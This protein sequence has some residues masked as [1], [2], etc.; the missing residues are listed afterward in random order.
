M[1]Y[2]NIH[3]S[4]TRT[5][6]DAN[7]YIWKII[8]TYFEDNPRSLVNH[9]IQSFND[10]YNQ[11]IYQVFRDTN[12]V[13]L[14][15]KFVNGEF[16]H[17]CKLYFGGKNGD[18]VYFG[19][20]AIYD[21]N[22]EHFMFPNEARLR[23][24]TYGMTI[25]YDIEVE[26][27][28]LLEEN[29]QPSIFTDEYLQQLE[30]GEIELGEED[31]EDNAEAFTGLFVQG[32]SGKRQTIKTNPKNAKQ[33]REKAQSTVHDRRTQALN[34]AIQ[35]A[36]QVSNT[37]QDSKTRVQIRN[38]VLEKIYLGRFPIM[39][40][41][42]MCILSGMTR[43][44]RLA[45]GE[46]KNDLGGYFI[47]DGKEKAVIPQEKLGD[48]MLNIRNFE[49]SNDNPD[50]TVGELEF[51]CTAEIKSVS[52]NIAK[53]RRT[54]SLK[55]VAPTAKY[56]NRNIVVNI[57]NVRKPVPLFIV[58]RALGIVSDKDI[59]Q[60]CLL[61]LDKYSDLVDLFIPCVHDAEGILTQQSA[62]YFISLLTK[63]KS[64]AY[65]HEI[66]TDYLLPHVGEGNYLEKAYYLGYMV[67]RM[68]SVHVG[69]E[70]PI[71]RD[72]FKYKRVE[73]VGSLIS[74]LFREYLTIQNKAY[75]LAFESRLYFNEQRYEDHLDLLIY[76]YYKEICKERIVETG[77]R[78]AFKGNWGSVAHTKRIGI[79]QDLNRLSF[80]S[81]IAHLRKVCLPM[82]SSLK[83]VEPR[84]LHPSQWGFIDPLDTP[85]GGNIGFHKNLAIST[86]ISR[87]C[88]R[89]VIL[90][91]LKAN[92]KVIVLEDLRP[93]LMANMSK[94]IVN[95]YWFACIED[96]LEAV[97]KMKLYRRNA[98]I[99]IHTSIAF[100][101]RLNTLFI[102]TDAGRLCRPIFYFDNGVLSY[103][104]KVLEGK[105]TW[106]E[107]IS[108]FNKKEVSGFDPNV[109]RIYSLKELYG[110]SGDQ[111]PALHD[112]FIKHKAMIDFIDCN[113][114]E[115]ALIALGVSDTDSAAAVGKTHCEIHESLIFG[116]MCNQI[117]FPENNQSP[118]D[119]FSCGQSKQACSMFH[120]NFQVRMDKTGIVLNYGQAPLVKTRYGTLINKEENPYGE[121][122][123]VAIMC[124]SGYNVEDAVLINEGAIKRGLFRTT[125]F[126]TYE[127]KEEHNK[128]D[129]DRWT[130]TILTNPN[131]Y[132][133]K[134]KLKAG[135]S[136]D[137]LD[138]FGIIREGVYVN[139]ET[140]LIGMSVNQ[141]N[142]ERRDCSI[143]PKKGQLGIVDKVFV[144][145]D[146]EGKRLIK[147]RVLDQRIPAMGDKFA[148]RVGQKGT[149]GIVIPER[150]MPFTKDGLIPDII[151]NPHA[152]PSR[153]T[154]GQIIESITGKVCTMYGGF[155]DC[156]AFN[157]KGSKAELFGKLLTKE[158]FHASGNEVLYNGMTGEQVEAD[159]FIGPT[160]YM[161]LKHMVKDKIN[162]RRQG[163]NAMLTRQPVG[164]RA[165]DGGL[166]VGEMER[167]TIAS[168]GAIEFLRESM[169]ERAD[170]YKLA[171]CNKTGTIAIHNQGQNRFLSPAVDGPIQVQCD[172][173]LCKTMVT[174]DEIKVDMVS[175]YG[176]DFSIVHVPYS[177]KLL[178][179]ELQ[180][181]NVQ[182]RIITEDNIKQLNNLMGNELQ[183]FQ[184]TNSTVEFVYGFKRGFDEKTLKPYWE[185]K[186]G[187]KVLKEPQVLIDK[188]K[189]SNMEMLRDYRVGD[190]IYYLDESVSMNPSEKWKIIAID[191]EE[192]TM[193]MKNIYSLG[194]EMEK[195][196]KYNIAV[197][198]LFSKSMEVTETNTTNATKKTHANVAYIQQVGET[199]YGWKLLESKNYPGRF[200]WGDTTGTDRPSKWTEPEE[201][202]E[203]RNI[204]KLPISE[205]CFQINEQFYDLSKY[206]D[207]EN[208]AVSAEEVSKLY[209][210]K[211]RFYDQD[212][213]AYKIVLENGDQVVFDQELMRLHKGYL[214][215]TPNEPPPPSTT[216][217]QIQTGGRA[218]K[219]HSH[220]LSAIDEL[221]PPGLATSEL[222]SVTEG[223]PLNELALDTM[224][225]WGKDPN[226]LHRVWYIRNL[227][228]D[229]TY[230]I[231]T[232]DVSGLQTEDC[233]QNVSREELTEI[234]KEDID[235]MMTP[236]CPDPM[237][238]NASNLPQ[239]MVFAPM[240]K[241]INNGA[242]NSTCATDPIQPS[243]KIPFIGMGG[244]GS[245]TTE[246]TTTSS[247]PISAKPTETELDSGDGNGE[248]GLFS[249][250]ASMAN[251]FI[252]KKLL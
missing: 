176:R 73:V 62:L 86:Q 202:T 146:E 200:Y 233:Y 94:V 93:S 168:H 35:Q 84:K 133:G 203:R 157:Q 106:N 192:G 172:A 199:I 228:E 179:Q 143:V 80:N 23:N 92:L 238:M 75:H 87:G 175:K 50:E 48:N 111:N 27:I 40:Q 109:P 160:Y 37:S 229:G 38:L 170:K 95:G 30:R 72:N 251:N 118:R 58:F 163:N 211:E 241:V 171:I 25:H 8:E 113:E 153:M 147:V 209:R 248:G 68:L 115:T 56:S 57:P 44:T 247:E 166:R 10:F 156:T 52:E 152:I 206:E 219:K 34:Q 194:D 177:L 13:T 59:I 232:D 112:K 107:L 2:Y 117:A 63:W 11:G 18:R 242:D 130:D 140:I 16:K 101:A 98:L 231:A 134:I 159:I 216:T 79:V 162:Y 129:D 81:M 141:E 212:Y 155:A 165:N 178:M 190:I 1:F 15:S 43:E 99:P 225:Y 185:D 7:E 150:D 54:L 151:V 71:D 220:S 142:G 201:I 12:P 149:I 65:V 77:F 227:G 88:S 144:T 223:C 174:D 128:E 66:L 90:P 91:W 29:E 83:I 24:M 47:I 226:K 9:H 19:K 55:L 186:E 236:A 249:K 164:G 230:Y 240:I 105:F 20:P 76:N 250:M 239:G 191:D 120:T 154:V 39:V 119:L 173:K 60:T 5:H 33:L 122:A 243:V 189:L 169:M 245:K 237:N 213:S 138:E 102:Y 145:D 205:R 235:A 127:A 46:C 214:P 108:G 167:D 198:R 217:Q 182:M 123:I 187:K 197:M 126:T 82:D 103:D 207:I 70:K 180:A 32:G 89:E 136:Y 181:I 45:A 221:Y 28:D 135:Y 85:D 100:D 224:V 244:G 53:P 6:D 26:F 110:I 196:C 67:S 139:D 125:Y 131:L 234:P 49:T 17:Q 188:R 208:Q 210:V 78:K 252:V 74:D 69:I 96:P 158:K 4:D 36:A 161:R 116:V 41:S 137:K 218:T 22:R 148:S 61:D 14:V 97:A 104:A 21:A 195:E 184:T 51:L 222:V 204:L 42:D 215:T 121:N 124:Y 183:A 114:T 64:I 31:D 193:T 132:K 246:A 3:M